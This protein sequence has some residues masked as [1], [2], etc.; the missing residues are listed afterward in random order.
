VAALVIIVFSNRNSAPVAETTQT[1]KADE[2]LMA[3][4][5]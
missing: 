2:K 5:K 4:I 1:S 3:E